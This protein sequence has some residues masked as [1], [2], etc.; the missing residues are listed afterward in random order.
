M[1]APSPLPAAAL[2]A[3]GATQGTAV[4]DLLHPFGSPTLPRPPALHG[5]TPVPAAGTPGHRTPVVLVHGYGGGRATW[6]ALRSRLAGA[7]FTDLHVMTY[8][9]LAPCVTEIAGT[10]ARECTDAMERAGTDRVHLIGH[11]LGG[12]VVR[13]AVQELGLHAHARTAVTVAAPHRGTLTAL[14]GRGSL[15]AQLRPGSRVLDDLR[16][17]ARPSAVRWVS[18][19]S[20]RDFVVRPHSAR[21]D[22]EA[23]RA[24]NVLVRGAGH[25]GIVRDPQFLGSVVHLLTH[26]TP[27]ATAV[28]TVRDRPP[29]AA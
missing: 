1:H 12:V 6:W 9:P 17:R 18:Y 2:E 14:L 28:P 19:W 16:R 23:L 24:T 25:L 13:Y 8:S 5:R 26:G 29:V 11:S 7:G 4:A 27:F 15:V 3:L 22:E 20:D 21:L 10:L